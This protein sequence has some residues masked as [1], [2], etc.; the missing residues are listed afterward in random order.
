[1]QEQGVD[2]GEGG[3]CRNTR[4]MRKDEVDPSESEGFRSPRRT[5]EYEVG[6]GET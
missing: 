3:E 2:A 6:A 5:P 4:R 1:M